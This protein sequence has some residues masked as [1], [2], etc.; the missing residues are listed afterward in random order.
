[1][2]AKILINF[3]TSKN[4]S[5][6]PGEVEKVT[7]RGRGKGVRSK[8]KEK[9]EEGK[10]VRRAEGR[11]SEVGGQSATMHRRASPEP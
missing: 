2:I 11:R 1:L 6:D 8:E 5:S 3:I 9:K 7:T 4:G 10:K